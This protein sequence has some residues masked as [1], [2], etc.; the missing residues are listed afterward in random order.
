MFLLQ[1]GQSDAGV[2]IWNG[3]SGG[4]VVDGA[5]FGGA[6]AAIASAGKGLSGGKILTGGIGADAG[7]G[8]GV[9]ILGAAGEQGVDEAGAVGIGRGAV[10]ASKVGERGRETDGWIV[11]VI[12][13]LGDGDGAKRGHGG[14]FIGGDTG[15]E[16]VG[17]R[18]GGDD[19]D[20]RDDD[21]QLD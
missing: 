19:Q 16:Q 20:D 11:V 2:V 21:Q 3:R 6:E 13:D 1:R 15:L 14:G 4:I 9:S 5:I 17:D 12:A 7:G 8:E 10:C 18:D